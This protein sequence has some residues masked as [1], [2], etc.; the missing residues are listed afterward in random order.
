MS[1]AR[2]SLLTMLFNELAP[3]TKHACVDAEIGGNCLYRRP[4]RASKALL[5]ACAPRS[6]FFLPLDT[7]HG[8]MSL[9]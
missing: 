2:N 8:L 3:A 7:S 4:V 9:F 6:I 5:L 1:L